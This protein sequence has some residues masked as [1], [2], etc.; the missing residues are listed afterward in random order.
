MEYLIHS[1]SA[2]SS[3]HNFYLLSW[4]WVWP[5][6]LLLHSSCLCF[7]IFFL[8]R[9]SIWFYFK[10]L[11]AGKV[12]MSSCLI[13]LLVYIFCGPTFNQQKFTILYFSVLRICLYIR[14]KLNIKSYMCLKNSKKVKLQNQY[15]TKVNI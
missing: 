9:K 11:V 1:F 4:I 12:M 5:F 8:K 13:W 10:S 2:F 7:I 14:M 6:L 3:I 15:M